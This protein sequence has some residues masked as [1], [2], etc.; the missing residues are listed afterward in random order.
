MGNLF[1]RPDIFFSAINKM[2]ERIWVYSLKSLTNAKIHIFNYDPNQ[3]KKNNV[4]CYLRRRRKISVSNEIYQTLSKEINDL[5]T[6]TY[7]L[8]ILYLL[9]FMV[10][11]VP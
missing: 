6:E 7:F 3:N 8:V 2:E 10:K 9:F 11:Y 4:I 5:Y 1:E